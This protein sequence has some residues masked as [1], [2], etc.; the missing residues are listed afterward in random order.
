MWTRMSTRSFQIR[1]RQ[2]LELRFEFF[3]RFNRANFSNP[4]ATL[5]SA[6][7][8]RYPKSR[9]T[10]AIRNWRAKFKF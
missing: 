4:V 5:S 6:S 1:E 9:R 3:N 10:Q 7:F 8:R 2:S